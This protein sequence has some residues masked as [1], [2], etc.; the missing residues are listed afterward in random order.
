MKASQITRVFEDAY[1]SPVS[2]II[3]D[4]IE[5]LLEYVAIG[6]RFSNTVLQVRTK[7][8]DFCD[9]L[10]EVR[11]S[12]SAAM[13]NCCH[14]HHHRHRHN[15]RSAAAAA[16]AAVILFATRPYL[17]V[18]AAVLCTCAS[19]WCRPHYACYTHLLPLS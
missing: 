1:R 12:C 13:F 15:L 17:A 9:V 7:C 11:L 14:H 4:D 16:A 18:T 6:P 19:V 5:R 2:I 3:I 8:P 10:L